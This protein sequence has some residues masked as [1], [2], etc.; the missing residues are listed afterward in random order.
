MGELVIP[1]AVLAAAVVLNYIFCL[2]P[3]RRGHCGSR[4]VQP[5]SPV[6]LDAELD[7]ARSE[8]KRLADSPAVGTDTQLGEPRASM[9]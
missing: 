2:R 7:R 4:V 9:P 1:V 6:D 8:L 3:M 5:A